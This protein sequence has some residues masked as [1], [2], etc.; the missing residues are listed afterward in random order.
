MER[1]EPVSFALRGV[2]PGGRFEVFPCYLESCHPERARQSP[3]RLQ[4][5][6]DLE[7]EVLSPAESIRY[8]PEV[9]S[10]YLA[11]WTSRRYGTAYR[12]F[13]AIE[14]TYVVYR[15]TVW[16]WPTPFPPTEGAQI[17]NGGLPLDWCI[18]PDKIDEPLALR[19]LQEQQRYGAGAVF[20]MPAS[21]ADGAIEDA[22]RAV[23]ASVASLRK[24]GL[25]VGRVA[26]L[27]YGGGLSNARV[28][29][30]RA[31]SF[32]VIDGSVPRA[33][34][35]GMS[36]PYFPFYIGPTD[37]RFPSQ[38][39]PTEAISCVSKFTGSWHFHGPIGFHRPSARGSWERARFYIDLAAQEAVLTARNSGAHNFLT[40]LIN[41]ESPVA[42]G[43]AAYEITWDEER[44]RDFFGKYMHLLAFEH[45]R[46][47]PIVFARAAD[48]ADYFRAHYSQMPRQI[49]SSIT[50]DPE[51]DR[52]WTDE[53]HEQRIAPRGYVPVHQSLRAFGRERAMPQYNMPMSPEFMNYNDNRRTCRFEY[54]CPK[55]V[56]CYDLTSATP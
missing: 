42:W 32:D 21:C 29:T 48:Y 19:L 46:R 52:F 17:N 36:A 13:A 2:T 33:S 4:W 40:T 20:G 24:R 10:N 25:D 28:Q 16:S 41:F 51:Y 55:P 45:T 47:W 39:G 44:G 26:N 27:W 49:V 1:G 12:Y 6:D 8:V 5:L 11:R 38:E 56:H 14:P 34:T 22:A 54:A 50:H 37:Y 15:P 3:E 31:E 43:D 23:R 35:C 9:E 18:E 53:W 30:A 7:R